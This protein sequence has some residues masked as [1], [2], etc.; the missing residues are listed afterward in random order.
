[1]L[2]RLAEVLAIQLVGAVDEV[3]LPGSNLQGK[4]CDY[5]TYTEKRADDEAAY[6]T[7]I[8]TCS[9]SGD[10]ETRVQIQANCDAR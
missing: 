3:H 2:G 10:P 7:W 8:L 4:Q 9:Y 5:S 6:R 1:M